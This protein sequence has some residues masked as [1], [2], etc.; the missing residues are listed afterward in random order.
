MRR[1]PQVVTSHAR[2]DTIVDKACGQLPWVGGRE[3]SSLEM[4]CTCVGCR[5]LESVARQNLGEASIGNGE[6]FGNHSDI[7]FFEHLQCSER[8]GDIRKARLLAR[9]ESASAGLVHIGEVGEF[10]AKPGTGIA[11]LIDVEDAVGVLHQSE[12][13]GELLE[14]VL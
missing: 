13:L 3:S 7:P 9:I 5:R 11:V 6:R 8:T 4:G 2:I 1:D 12:E 14:E 10:D